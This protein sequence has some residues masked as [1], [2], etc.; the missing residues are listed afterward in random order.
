[1]YM[2]VTHAKIAGATN[3]SSASQAD[4]KSTQMQQHARVSMVSAVYE[5]QNIWADALQNF[6]KLITMLAWLFITETVLAY[7]VS[8]LILALLHSSNEYF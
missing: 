5:Y 3:T 2:T 7:G 6:N 1:M 4:L 8:L